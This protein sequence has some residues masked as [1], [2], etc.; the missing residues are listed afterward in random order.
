MKLSMNEIQQFTH[1]APRPLP[2]IL[3]VDISG[4]MMTDGKIEILNN[5]VSEMIGT[6]RDEESAVAQ[7]QVAVITFG[8][9]GAQLQTPLT[10]AEN[11]AW[12]NMSA[13]GRTPMGSAFQMTADMIEDREK[14]P[15][16][17]YR[18]TLVLV[19]DGIPTDDWE[20]PLQHLLSSPR[21]SKATR[22]ALAIGED[23]SRETLEKFVGDS[24]HGVFEADQA[25]QIRK[26]FKWVTMSV[27]SRTRS[28]NPN[29][30]T[31][32]DLHDLDDVE[33]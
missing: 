13:S 31:E 17:A 27:T 18:P 28:T 21:A 7:I 3:L 8:G 25:R 11:L 5:A 6:F 24:S 14:I 1:A 16:R 20:Q 15:G 33:F 9:E 4:S 19:S 22:F 30:P 23:A 2:V 26:F 29:Q 12:T 10:P 32:I